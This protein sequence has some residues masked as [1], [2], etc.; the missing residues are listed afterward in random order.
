LV[1]STKT[2]RSSNSTRRQADATK[3]STNPYHRPMLPQAT[4]T[5]AHA[6]VQ[7]CETKADCVEHTG[8]LPPDCRGAREVPTQQS[9]HSVNAA[10]ILLKTWMRT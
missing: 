4:E 1:F 3:A 8:M 7:Q 2:S 5:A 10:D 6:R 9:A